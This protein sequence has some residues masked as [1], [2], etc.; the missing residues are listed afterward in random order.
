MGTS[1][2]PKDRR[3]VSLLGQHLEPEKG[4]SCE[5]PTNKEYADI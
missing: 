4:D 1:T 2:E 3:K 5:T